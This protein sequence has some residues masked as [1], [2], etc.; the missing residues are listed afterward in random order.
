ME[1][2]GGGVPLDSSSPVPCSKQSS[3][4]YHHTINPTEVSCVV[5]IELTRICAYS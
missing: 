1:R 4:D 5:D 2:L 3:R